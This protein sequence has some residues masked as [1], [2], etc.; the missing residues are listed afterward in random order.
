MEET[1]L[2]T[3]VQD[4]G[5]MINHILVAAQT[6]G[7]NPENWFMSG[8]PFDITVNYAPELQEALAFLVKKYVDLCVSLYYMTRHLC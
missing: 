5:D 7:A 1:I 6:V 8:P 2:A 4:H 3:E